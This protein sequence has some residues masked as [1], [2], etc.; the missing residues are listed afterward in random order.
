MK[1][2][3]IGAHL[4]LAG[5]SVRAPTVVIREALAAFRMLGH[6]LVFQP[7]LSHDAE[8]GFEEAGER[9]LAW[10]RE[11]GIE[12]LPP[13]YAPP[14]SIGTTPRQLVRQAFSSDPA[15]F[16]PSYAL[17]GQLAERVAR[18]GADV[19]FHL[20]TSA[21]FGACAEVETPVYAY[22]GNPDHYSMEARLKHPDLFAVPRK[23]ARNRVKL[24]L[25]RRAYRRF[26][27]VVVRLALRSTWLGC[28]SAPNAEYYA[29]HGHPRSFYVQNMWPALAHEETVPEPTENRIVGNLGGQYA[30]GNTF[31]GWLLAREVL[32]ALDR[33]LGEDYRVHLYGAGEFVAPLGE[34]LRHPRVVNDGFV[35]DIDAELQA[36]KVFLLCNN[37]NPDYVVGHTRILHAWSVG[38]CLVAH[39][40]MAR[41]MPEI[42]H[43]ENALLGSTGE[44]LAEQVA[45]ACRDDAL[46]RRIVEGGK[47][48]WEREFQPLVVVDRV[49]RRIEADL[50]L[51]SGSP[52]AAR[53]TPAPR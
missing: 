7:L 6:D 2:L 38:S 42:V 21:A 13:L 39:V 46:R 31:G 18:S 53:P 33:L 24:I 23:T 28:V 14:D 22:A 29:A 26:E 8:E 48:T 15:D 12:L 37:S 52:A 10:A 41:A 49:V 45:R 51:G 43:G 40:D 4:P 47:R 17:R 16:Y 5:H 50:R 30:T 34:A 36:A 25:W 20:W 27:D 35:D 32:P 19:V 9:A 11:A 3:F 1:V 44:E